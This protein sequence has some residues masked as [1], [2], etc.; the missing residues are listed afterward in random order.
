MIPRHLLPLVLCLGGLARCTHSLALSTPNFGGVEAMHIGGGSVD[1]ELSSKP[2]AVTREQLTAWIQTAAEAVSTYYGKFPVPRVKLEIGATADAHEIH[3]RTYDGRRIV[4]EL[5]PDVTPADL[6]SDWVMTHEMFHLAFPDMGDAHEWMNEGLSTYL[7]PIARA[8]IGQLS[9][10]TVWGDMAEGLPQGQ[11]KAGDRGLD[12][13]HTW[14]RTYWGGCLF[15]FLADVQIR[16]QSHGSR[17]LQDALRA[18]LDAGG[19]GSVTW[20]VKQVIE[21]GDRATGTTVL[22]ALYAQMAPAPATID[23]ADLWRRLGVRHAEGGVTF[24]DGA[25]LAKVRS[26]IT[27]RIDPP[28]VGRSK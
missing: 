16:Q 4:I 17:S 19:D 9:P 28:S 24:D 8:N 10:Q 2:A 25:P 22:K 20:S 11:P 27:A 12:H 3:G 1:V 6:N 15:W 18:I 13:T 23:L 7:E 5:G 26:S 21:R 14:A